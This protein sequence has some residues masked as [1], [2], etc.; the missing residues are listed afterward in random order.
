MST[1]LISR[2]LVGFIV[3]LLLSGQSSA[4]GG[5]GFGQGENRYHPYYIE[6]LPPEIRNTIIHQC[7]APKAT[8]AFARYADNLQKVVLRYEHFYCSAGGT[9]CDPSG[10]LHQVYVSSHGHYR[11]VRSYYA[12]GGE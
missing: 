7:G 6:S 2:C 12:P 8:Q 5:G 9:F 3:V 11:L 10:C 4:K 1:F